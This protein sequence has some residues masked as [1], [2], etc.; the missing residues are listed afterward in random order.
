MA[1]NF[2]QQLGSEIYSNLEYDY[3]FTSENVYQMGCAKNREIIGRYTESLLLPGSR[4]N[5]PESLAEL[6]HRSQ[7]GESCLIMAE[8][9]SNLDY[10]LFYRLIENTPELGSDVAKS[11]LP[12]RGMKLTEEDPL[13]AAY[14]YSYDGIVIYPSRSL[15]SITDPA[16]LEKV[17]TLSRPI[18]HAAIRAMIHH[19]NNGRIILVF[20]SGTR[21]RPWDPTSRRGVREIYS[22]LKIFDNVVFVAINGNALLPCQ[23]GDMRK[24][25]IA[26]DLIL[27]TCSKV[28]DGREFKREN[29]KSVPEGKE[30]RQHVVDMVMQKLL[31]MHTSIEPKRLAEKATKRKI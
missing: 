20:P 10:P 1:F 27:F 18:N 15:D 22:Y 23:E 25:R 3:S 26:E 16:E 17:R 14:A 21:Y 4:I 28:I 5:N 9:Y 19:K 24:D 7:S 2:I 29:E 13:I 6:M 8:H 30:Q 12:I 31:D 11:V